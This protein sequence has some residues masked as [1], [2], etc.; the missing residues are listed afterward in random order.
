MTPPEEE[1]DRED[2]GEMEFKMLQTIRLKAMAKINLGLDVLRRR[3]D[4][5]HDVRMIMQTVNLYDDIE[6]TKMEEPGIRIFTNLHFLPANENNLAYC[7]AD[8]LMKEF[9]LQGGLQIKLDKHIPVAAGMAG[10]SSDGAAVLVGLNRMFSLGL[11]K[12]ELAERGVLLGADVPYCIM[13]GT[14][15]SEGIGEIL[16]P[17]PPMPD[18]QILIARPG[19]AVS[20]RFVYENLHAEAITDHPDID[21][22]I[23]A[24]TAGDL[25]KVAAKMENV[26]E[27]VTVPAYPEIGRLKELMREKGALNALMSGSGPTVFGLFD[28]EETAQEACDA[29]M[30]SGLAKQLFLR[31]P[32]QNHTR[33]YQNLE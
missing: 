27:R 17:L 24:L 31:R 19:I 23:E 14:A 9:S 8:L 11:S 25:Y 4:G 29:V 1:T 2:S 16:T 26:L 7:A 5:Y 12:E 18:C 10:G 15:L 30:E 28:R 21:G 32:F 6:I 33:N 20:T 3:P 13:R 22:M